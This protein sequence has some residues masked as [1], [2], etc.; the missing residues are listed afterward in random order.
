M[1]SHVGEEKCRALET[2]L[3]T[4]IPGITCGFAD[5]SKAYR[6][7]GMPKLHLDGDCSCSHTLY[8]ITRI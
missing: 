6:E 5:H 2:V 4:S 7:M 8:W 3:R 1:V